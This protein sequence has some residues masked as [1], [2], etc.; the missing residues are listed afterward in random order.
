LTERLP[1]YL[2]PAEVVVLETLPLT[3]NGDI[4]TRALPAPETFVDPKIRQALHDVFTRLLGVEHVGVADSFFELGGDSLSAMRAVTA[5]NAALD[6]DLKVSAVFN[7]PTIAQLAARINGNAGGLKPLVARERPAVVPL[8]FAQSRL[9]FIAQL[10]GPSPVY[11]RSV[12]LRLR[13]QLDVEALT[14][15]LVDLVGRHESLR[16]VFSAV[17][18]IPQQLIIS[19]E[20]ADFGWGV[21]DSTGWPPDR[22]AEA[23]EEAA[24]YSFDLGIDIPFRTRLFRVTDQEH[25]LLITVHH[26]AGDGWSIGVL[27]ADL[28]EA[29]LSRCAGRLPGWAELPVQYVDYALWQRQNLGDAADRNSPLAAQVGYWE[30][31]LA[32]IPERLQLPTDRPYPLVADHRGASVAVEWPAELQQRVGSLAREHNSTSFMVVQAALAA[33]LSRLSAATDVAVGFPIAGRGDPALD[34]LIGFFVNTLILRVDLAGDPSFTELLAQVRE[35]SLA[36]YEH[37]DVPFEAL[38][39]RL[40]PPR[41]RTHHPLIQVTLAWQNFT[42]RYD[43]PAA[44]LAL[45]DLQATPV[46]L[47]THTARMDLSFFLAE[48]FTDT[49]GPAGIGGTV[50]FRTDVYDTATVEA[51]IGRLQKVLEAVTADPGRR[52]SS[53]DLLDPAEHARL[54]GWGNRTV[55]AGEAPVT[56]SSIT[57]LWTAQVARTPDADAVTCDGRSMTYRE[58]D[59]AA[60]RLAHR[61]AGHGVGPSDVVALLFSRSAEAI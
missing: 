39:E 36:A 60:D 24:R 56:E 11:N 3:V 32:G 35:R 25:V 40:N 14:A 17:D 59:Q 38:V 22:L 34:G 6:V 55:L 15:A 47:D 53:I 28:G 5:I 16:T 37:Q 30:E 20:R 33:L 41:S 26:I 8:S 43:D 19:A 42:W 10:Q 51:L 45:G 46:A 49:G 50:E 2:V 13:G 29:Y 57:T 12:A 1:S 27:A 21:V 23:I 31:V 18:G 9:W 7:A 61:L 44:G 48:R 54:D 4:D 58:L 52:T